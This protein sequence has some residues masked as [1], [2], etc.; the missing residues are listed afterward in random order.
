MSG[1]SAWIAS[2]VTSCLFICFH[3]PRLLSFHGTSLQQVSVLLDWV[4]VFQK[5]SYKVSENP[6]L[7]ILQ[8]HFYY[9][10]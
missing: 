8:C 3:S 1:T 5:L 2:C 7:E 9:I 10:L 4:T 6:E